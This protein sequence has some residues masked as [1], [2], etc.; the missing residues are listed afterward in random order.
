MFEVNFPFSIFHESLGNWW[1]W[2][3]IPRTDSTEFHVENWW[4][5]EVHK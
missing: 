3:N 1:K 2:K 5:M 4:K